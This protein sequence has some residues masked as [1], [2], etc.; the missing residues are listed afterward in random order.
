MG[1]FVQVH[2]SLP[3]GSAPPACECGLQ[4]CKKT[5]QKW[6]EDMTKSLRHRPGPQIPAPNPIEHSWDVLDKSDQQKLSSLR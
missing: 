1:T 3:D 5:A 6:P 4:A 2:C